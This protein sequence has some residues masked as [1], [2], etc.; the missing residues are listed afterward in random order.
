MV[1]FRPLIRP[2]F[3]RMV[4][5]SSSAC[6]GCSCAPSP[7]LMTL[8]WT[9]RERK[10][11]APDALWRMTMKSIFSA[12]RLRAVSLRV[13]PFLSEEASAVKLMMSAERR[14]SDSS[15]L[16]RV[17]VDGS[18]NRLMT[19]LPRRAGT[20]FMARLPTA[21]KARAVSSTSVISSAVRDSMS[22][23]CL[24]CQVMGGRGVME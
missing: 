21:L 14:C 13:S 23:R 19:V 24:R 5:A 17:R 6:V 1:T 12:S 18:I 8:A 20:F 4:N 7:A 15:K 2:F 16:V 11:G 9:T 10:W 3:S 22:S